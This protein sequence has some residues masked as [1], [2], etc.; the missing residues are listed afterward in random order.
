[1]NNKKPNDL[2]R[3]TISVRVPRYLKDYADKSGISISSMIE[4]DL[5]SFIMKL[6]VLEHLKANQK[7]L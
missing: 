6:Y 7:R 5:N 3:I 4:K 2:E 1:M